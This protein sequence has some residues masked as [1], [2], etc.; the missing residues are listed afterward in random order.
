MVFRNS[1]KEYGFRS[2]HLS[3]N[4]YILKFLRIKQGNVEIQNV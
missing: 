4:M 3:V 1:Y 2:I